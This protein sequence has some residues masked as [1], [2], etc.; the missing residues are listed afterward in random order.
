VKGIDARVVDWVTRCL[1]QCNEIS[2]N[3]KNQDA[4]SQKTIADFKSEVE[5]RFKKLDNIPEAV[6]KEFVPIE[7]KLL[8]DQTD[9]FKKARLEIMDLVKQELKEKEQLL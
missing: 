4:A 9:K 5:L 1:K 2:E 7:K 3:V 8:Q 6:K